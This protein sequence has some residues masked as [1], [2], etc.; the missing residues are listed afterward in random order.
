VAV[1]SLIGT[2]KLN[3]IDPESYLRYVLTHIAQ[4]PINRVE[5]LL[6]WCVVQPLW[7]FLCM[8]PIGLGVQGILRRKP[9]PIAQ[10]IEP[11]TP[12]ASRLRHSISGAYSHPEFLRWDTD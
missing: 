5:E 11:T 10:P 6:P 12:N 8:V 4:H 3:D 7:M 1:Y 2:A 9:L